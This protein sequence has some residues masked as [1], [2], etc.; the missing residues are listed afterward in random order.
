M[1][2]GRTALVLPDPQSVTVAAV[3]SVAVQAQAVRERCRETRDSEMTLELLRRLAAFRGYVSDRKARAGLEGELRLTEVLIGELRLD[4]YFY[5]E[6]HQSPRTRDEYKPSGINTTRAAYW[7]FCIADTNVIVMVP[8]P[9]VRQ[10]AKAARKVS[11]TDGDNPT[12]GRLTT[13]NEFLAAAHELYDTA[14]GAPTDEPPPPAPADTDPDAAYGSFSD[15][16]HPDRQTAEYHRTGTF[17]PD[18][19]GWT[20][21]S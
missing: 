12:K 13:F 20:R 10:A 11:E 8:T 21:P 7:A 18:D 3:A 5:V 1:S 17:T 4:S 16:A 2:S 15:D 19:N 6:T 14:H 9:V